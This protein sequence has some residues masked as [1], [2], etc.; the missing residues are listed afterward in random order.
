MSEILGSKSVR[1]YLGDVWVQRHPDVK[2]AIE[3]LEFF[4]QEELKSD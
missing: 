4:L 2:P 3:K 1:Q